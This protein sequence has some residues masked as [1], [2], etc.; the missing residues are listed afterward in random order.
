[1]ARSSWGQML[2]R[3]KVRHTDRQKGKK[4]NTKPEADRERESSKC[5]NLGS[6]LVFAINKWPTRPQTQTLRYWDYRSF[7]G[8]E[9]LSSKNQ[10]VGESPGL[11]VTGGDSCSKGRGFE[12]G[13]GE[14]S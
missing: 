7:G 10:I 11:V 4:R 6:S 8:I 3:L 14:I 9:L 1:M 12:S 13:M 2:K 5:P